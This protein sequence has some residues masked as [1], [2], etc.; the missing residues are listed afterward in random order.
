MSDDTK[1]TM[2]DGREALGA[3]IIRP[4]NPDNPADGVEV[5]AYASGL[6]HPQMAS[7]L[8]TV[9]DRFDARND[10]HAPADDDTATDRP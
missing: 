5:E 6:S 8:R 1:L 10:T 3:A 9:A 7:I 2:I 4:K